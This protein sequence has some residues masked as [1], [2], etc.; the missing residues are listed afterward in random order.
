MDLKESDLYKKHDKLIEL[1]KATYN[2]L[3][4]KC[5]KKIK[6]VANIGELMCLFEI[7]YFYI[8][9]RISHY[10]CFIMC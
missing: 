3:Y 8:R 4:T 5:S 10:Q 7:P 1:K 2:Q 6:L 9:Q